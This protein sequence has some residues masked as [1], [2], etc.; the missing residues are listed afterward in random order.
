MRTEIVR[1]IDDVDG[2]E[3]VETVTFA[4]DGTGY[5]IDVNEKHATALRE[6]FEEWIA[7]ATRLGKVVIGGRAVLPAAGRARNEETLKVRAWA[8]EHGVVVAARGRISGK[9]LEA[10]RAGNPALAT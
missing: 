1:L 6:S 9:V 2:S 8:Q 4:L 3:A 10:Y 7:S 5:T